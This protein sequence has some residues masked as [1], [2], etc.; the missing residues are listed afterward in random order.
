[1]IMAR[2]PTDT[3]RG[4]RGPGFLRGHFQNMI[5]NGFLNFYNSFFPLLNTRKYLDTKATVRIKPLNECLQ[6]SKIF[7]DSTYEDFHF[8]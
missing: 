2:P 5:L 1:M 4:Y 8:S 3:V 7:I 6:G